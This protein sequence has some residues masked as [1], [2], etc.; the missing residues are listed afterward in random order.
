[1]RSPRFLEVFGIHCLSSSPPCKLL[2]SERRSPSP[3]KSRRRL[4]VSKP[5]SRGRGGHRK[6]RVM[7][8]EQLPKFHRLVRWWHDEN[9]NMPPLF[10]DQFPTNFDTPFQQIT[11]DIH[12]RNEREHVQREKYRK[13][14]LALARLFSLAARDCRQLGIQFVRANK[15]YKKR[16]VDIN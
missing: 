5:V 10:Y 2:Q 15:E 3:H 1:M 7:R 8:C 13:F 9:T 6:P 11:R 16:R 14:W 12:T 4:R